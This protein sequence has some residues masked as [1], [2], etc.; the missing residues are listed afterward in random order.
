MKSPVT[1]I[2]ITITAF[3]LGAAAG[4]QLSRDQPAD[5]KETSVVPAA[6]FIHTGIRSDG[7]R[8]EP[9][10]E[11]TIDDV[12]G[13]ESIFDQLHMAYRLA[14]NSDLSQ[15]SS[16][17]E[18]VLKDSD[19][20]FN[21]NIAGIFIEKMIAIDPESALEFVTGHPEMNQGYF[22]SHVLTSWIRT[23]PEPALDYFKSIRNTQLRNWIGSRLLA[24]ST[25]QRSGLMQEVEEALGNAS[26]DLV[27]QARLN[28]MD[29]G[30]AF[31]EAVQRTDFRRQQSM[32]RAISRWYTQDP[33]AT[34]RRMTE[35]TDSREREMLLQVII[36]LESRNDPEKAL[37]LVELYASD[38]QNL[39]Q[40][41]LIQ[42]AQRDPV[43]ALPRIE[44]LVA[45]TGDRQLLGQL[46]SR[47]IQLDKQAAL[48]YLDTVPAD[49]REEIYQFMV[50]AYFS[51]SPDEA[52]QWLTGLD[53]KYQSVRQSGLV[54]LANYPDLAESWIDRLA[55]EPSLKAMLI[56]QIAARKARSNPQAALTWLG[57]HRDS[58]G[59]GNA[60]SSVLQVWAQRDPEAVAGLLEDAED[61]PPHQRYLFST[62][63][64]TWA[65]RDAD[66]AISWIGS[67][68][69][70]GNQQ[71]AISGLL[72]R[73]DDVETAIPL[74]DMV[75]PE[76]QRN[77][78]NQLAYHLMRKDPEALES[79]IERLEID[80]VQADSLIRQRDQMKEQWEAGSFR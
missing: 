17:V 77:L 46:V 56:T 65:R 61:S 2:V 11:L 12:Y 54:H 79:F 78:K 58:P 80:D 60:R 8:K 44:A 45:E 14:T 47:W 19:P 15:L 76:A 28:R 66:A 69:D 40:Q 10:R 1:T 7:R 51:Q 9:S 26:R 32:I 53:R 27:E 62:I 71:L 63:A 30:D 49:S 42:I 52:M 68:S 72:S 48:A 16:L 67:L 41:A 20:L 59:F 31:E 18:R 37:E 34:L 55:S 36:S 5:S 70:S 21:R 13:Q 75:A 74:I 24:D 38:N 35:M 23:D 73:L 33:E 6:E 3:C 4:F 29:P 39:K 64:S 25:L 57:R 43:G 22:I 50:G